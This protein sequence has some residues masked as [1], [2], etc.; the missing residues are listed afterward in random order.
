MNCKFKKLKLLWLDLSF[1][2]VK[3]GWGQIRQTRAG[4]SK[5]SVCQNMD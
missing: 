1:N 4:G 5:G 2:G 3:T